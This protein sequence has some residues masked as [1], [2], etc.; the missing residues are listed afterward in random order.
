M[1]TQ[2]C[3]LI[4]DL[5]ETNNIS[6]TAEN[7]GYSQP[8]ASHIIKTIEDEFGF[9]IIER[10]K[11]GIRLTEAAKFLI[12]NIR[13]ILNSEEALNETIAG[14][15]GLEIGKVTIGA[16]TSVATHLLPNVLKE[17]NELHP[18]IEI[19]I[20]EGGA[21]EII[22]WLNDDIVDLAFISRPYARTIDFISYGK[23][24]LVAVLPLDFTERYFD[25]Y[26]IEA[27]SGKPFILTAYGND[28]DINNALE[29]S[30]V[31]PNVKYTVLDDQTIMAMVSQ[32]LGVS[33]LT[34]LIT[35]HNAYEIR[36]VPIKPEFYRDMGIGMKNAS[37]L[38]PAASQF[39]DFSLPI[40]KEIWKF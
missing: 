5:S 27:I 31:K 10:Q 25:G 36:T 16:Y 9:K 21:D 6:R 4:L 17:F 32:N 8:G 34:R 2:Q 15:K 33:I 24:P 13:N 1:T 18:G 28:I 23:D 12:P 29:V 30:G 7:L 35:E 26:P 19:D 20:R 40:L 38:T 22:N 3:R 37:Y 11:Y 39:V 14:L